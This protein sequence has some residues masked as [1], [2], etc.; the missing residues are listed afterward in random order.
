MVLRIKL[1]VFRTAD[2]AL[3]LVLAGRFPAGVVVLN[4]NDLFCF[5]CKTVRCFRM[6]RYLK[7]VFFDRIA[8]RSKFNRIVAVFKRCC[9]I[10]ADLF[11]LIACGNEFASLWECK[12]EDIILRPANPVCTADHDF[13]NRLFRCFVAAELALLPILAVFALPLV[14][15]PINYFD[16]FGGTDKKTVGGGGIDGELEA[17]LGLIVP[18]GLNRTVAHAVITIAGLPLPICV[19]S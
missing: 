7:A 11:K 6:N 15:V 9:K 2:L 4:R 14:S 8:G 17:C 16:V 12:A 10:A 1:T 19:N 5:D 18:I 13:G 3:C